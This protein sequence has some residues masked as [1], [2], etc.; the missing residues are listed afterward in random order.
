MHLRGHTSPNHRRAIR[1]LLGVAL[2][3]VLLLAGTA[4]PAFADTPDPAPTAGPGAT[5]VP[6]Q[7]GNP[8]QDAVLQATSTGQAVAIPSLTTQTATVTAEP[9]GTL[10]QSLSVLPERV[11]QNG[12][13]TPVDATLQATG[14]GGYSPAATPNGAV[15]SSGGNGP[16]VTLTN[17]AG[18]AL[19]LSVPFTLPAP[20]VSANTALYPN[21][22]PGVDLQATISDQ[23]GFHEVLIVHNATAAANPDLAELTFSAATTGLTLSTS[24]ADGLVAT[25]T[26]GTAAY[27]GS[28]PLMWDSTTTP[29]TNQTAALK[30]D[31]LS[32]DDTGTTTDSTDPATSTVDAPGAGAQ[33]APA[34]LITNGDQVTLTPD[35]SLLTGSTTTYPVYIDPDVNPLPSITPQG[36]DQVY[37][38]S[39]CDNVN[40]YNSPQENGEGA[41]YM[42]FAGDDT[43]GYGL[44]R[45]Y[46][47]LN[48]SSITSAMQ[49]YK[50]TE[51]LT[52]TDRA[53]DSCTAHDPV[54]LT[55]T[56]SIGYVTTWN[57]QPGN[58][59][60]GTQSSYAAN[61]GTSGSC[62]DIPVSIDVT[63]VIQD[64]GGTHT[65]WAFEVSTDETQ[66]GSNL[67]F[68]RFSTNPTLVV[69]YDIAPN[70]P[71]AVKTTPNG[72]DTTTCNNNSTDWIGKTTLSGD[73][74]AID[75]DATITSNISG[76]LITANYALWD[77]STADSAGTG[78]VTYSV[79][80]DTNLASGSNA[81][82]P[83]GITVKDGHQYGWGVQSEDNNAVLHLTSPWISECH[84]NVDLTAPATPT[85]TDSTVFPPTSN[86][87]TPSGYAGDSTT[88]TVSS[89][90][91]VPTGC[92]LNGACHASGL[93]GFYW[94]MDAQPATNGANFVAA[95]GGTAQIPLDPTTWGTHSLYIQAVDNAGNI[96]ATSAV[97]TFYAPWNPN[98]E[99]A[100]GDLDGDGVPDLLATSTDNNLYLVH[101]NTNLTDPDITTSSTPTAS[102]DSG[103]GSTDSNAGQGWS[104]DLI[105]HRGSVDQA[106]HDDL[107]AYNTTT[108][109]MYVYKNDASPGESGTPGDFTN[110]ANLGTI[111][112]P[113]CDSTKTTCT[114]YPSDWS[115]VTAMIAPGDVY[116]PNQSH[117]PL[118]PTDLITVQGINHNL[119]LYQGNASTLTQ[120]CLLATGDWS[121]MDLIAPGIVNGTPTL[122]AR[123][124]ATG[125]L[126][127]Y[128]ITT[129]STTTCPT[130]INDPL[131]GATPLNLNLPTTTYPV[132]ASPGDINSPTGGP[133]GNPDLYTINTSGHLIEYPGATPTGTT[134][135]FTTPI[136][137]ETLTNYTAYTNMN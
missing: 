122:W 29:V 100:P 36:Y 69:D 116:D 133:D 2:A 1:G 35:Q 130:T 120:P 24:S 38:S 83:I 11:Q 55:S 4:G 99:V 37:S 108:K 31:A 5:T 79:P 65:D 135:S 59:G 62:G 39:S 119:W 23:G 48:I 88:L 7:G 21:V 40:N 67:D 60:L 105:A 117:D 43:C 74:N 128:P 103:T 121:G 92:T 15:L 134:A 132:I 131:T 95:S 61:N 76:E 94:A 18:N 123:D 33:I 126:Y 42:D 85:V 89:S 114:D 27:S 72:G 102:P 34:D 86:G 77:N 63:S 82:E 137:L 54:D 22:L 44:E 110:T 125:T 104:H 52:E 70:A 6:A 13:W 8:T 50:A 118:G 68:Q 57:D 90:D 136:N 53:N 80:S 9:D 127:T 96:Q 91:P 41:G 20:T 124:R 17:P 16:L 14:T 97:Y 10:S 129:T 87:Q 109:Q 73:G 112:Y 30:T 106:G 64:I 32:S 45:S 49:I 66:S 115:T 78:P 46:Y 58:A 51:N 47:E 111:T 107:Y 98:T 113:T 84:F 93:K 28:T 101:G 81:K 71:T 26:E 12:T 75:L 56:G 25:N 3:G 19:S